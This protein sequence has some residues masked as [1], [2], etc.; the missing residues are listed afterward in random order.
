MIYIVGGM[1]VLLCVH[2]RFR[3]CVPERDRLFFGSECTQILVLENLKKIW[4]VSFILDKKINI[5]LVF[6]Y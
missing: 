6:S 1:H 3:S 5:C 2:T 4:V